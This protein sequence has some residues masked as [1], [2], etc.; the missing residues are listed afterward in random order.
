MSK[1]HKTLIIELCSII[2]LLIVCL[3]GYMIYKRTQLGEIQEENRNIRT[4]EKEQYD[5]ETKDSEEEN[6]LFCD[7]IEDVHIAFDKETGLQYAN[8]QLL[9]TAALGVKKKDVEDLIAPYQAEIV[10]MIGRTND[11]QIKFNKSYEKKELDKIGEELCS[12]G[13]IV[14]YTVNAVM[15]I[16]ID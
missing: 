8:N 4:E 6:E 13:K 10:G 15:N 3:G 7:G 5:S 2:T 16:N 12:T 11:Y 1:S 14:E 9:L